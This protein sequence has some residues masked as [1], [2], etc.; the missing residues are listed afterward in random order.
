[1][2]TIADNFIKDGSFGRR[3]LAMLASFY[4]I[5][6]LYG[7]YAESGTTST[8]YE[9]V[10]SALR[11]V[12]LDGVADW[13]TGTLFEALSTSPVVP[14]AGAA[15]IVGAVL[16]MAA[17][18]RRT[19]YNVSPQATFAYLLALCLLI[20]LEQIPLGSAVVGTAVIAIGFGGFCLLPSDETLVSPVV[21]ALLMFIAPFAAILYGPAKILS[22]LATES[23]TQT[24]PVALEHGTGPLRI[25]IVESTAPT[26][27]RF[28]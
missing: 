17:T 6:L 2:S 23:R 28:M 24:V 9:T 3:L 19:V 20:D 25:E 11:S 13:T 16:N 21:A 8:G 14:F 12:G 5:A 15:V 10:A 22:W 18:F 27:A 7:R 26:G 4:A 1:M